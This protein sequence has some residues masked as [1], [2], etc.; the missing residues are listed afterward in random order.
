MA[1]LSTLP[2]VQVIQIHGFADGAVAEYNAADTAESNNTAS[3]QFTSAPDLTIDGLTVLTPALV[4]GGLVD[5]QWTVRNQ[6][7]APTPTGWFDHIIVS[8]VDTGATLLNLDVFY[9]PTTALAV[10]DAATPCRLR[11]F[12]KE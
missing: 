7:N 5:L 6:G 11:L 8:N 3:T 12:W 4:S 10:G 1:L 2:R 9:T